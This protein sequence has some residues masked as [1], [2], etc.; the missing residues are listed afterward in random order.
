MY[1]AKMTECKMM[2]MTDG[3]HEGSKA[4]S[5]QRST[6]TASYSPIAAMYI[7]VLSLIYVLYVCTL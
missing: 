3:E 5:K 2:I 7:I 4:D 6:L 1:V